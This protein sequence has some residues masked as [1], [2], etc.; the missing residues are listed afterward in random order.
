MVSAT[1][2][3]RRYL[4][5]YFWRFLPLLAGV[6]LACLPIAIGGSDGVF[7]PSPFIVR[8]LCKRRQ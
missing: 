8:R 1:R 6:M 2:C 3:S 4:G 5:E 7:A